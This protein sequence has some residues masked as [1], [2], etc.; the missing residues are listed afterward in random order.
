LV[1]T[2]FACQVR[3]AVAIHVDTLVVALPKAVVLNGTAERERL[4]V[5]GLRGIEA[6]KTRGIG[7]A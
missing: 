2:E 5:H 6:Q 4:A 7:P 1:E 3:D